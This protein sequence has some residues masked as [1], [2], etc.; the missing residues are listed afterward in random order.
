MYLP[1]HFA[2]PRL[3]VLQEL[4]QCQ[5]LATIITLNQNGINA[6]HIPLY[7]DPQAGEF[8][9]LYGHVARAN[10]IWQEHTS[11]HEILAIFHGS[12]SY[13]TPSW[14][15]S[16]A[17]TGRVVP[18]WN[19]AVAHAYGQL[20]VI[21]DPQWL[22]QQLEHLTNHNEA[23]FEHQWQ[24]GDAPHEYTE[25]LLK[26]IVGIAIPITRLLGKWKVSQNQ[27]H[28]NQ[29]SVIAGLEASNEPTAAAMIELIKQ[30]QS[31]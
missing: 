9:T 20:Q 18:T 11:Q 5:P 22:R 25:A 30:R 8:G 19:Y 2:E 26:A 29:Q 15:A 6:N 4:I 14:Y 31:S 3:E 28:A 23:S 12:D 21:D 17:Q 7:L 1:K 24:V 10:S 16:K 13:I 27:P